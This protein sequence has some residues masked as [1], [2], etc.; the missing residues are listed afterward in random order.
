MKITLFLLF[1]FTVVFAANS[2]FSRIRVAAYDSDGVP[3]E[4]VH[5]ISICLERN[6][7]MDEKR[8][9]EEVLGYYADGIYEATN[10]ANFLGN[11]IIYSGA[12]NCSEAD[13]VWMK[14]G[15]WPG[16]GA[17][18]GVSDVWV[19]GSDVYPKMDDAKERFDFGITLAHETIHL[20]Y[21]LDDDYAKTTSTNY[22]VTLLADSHND[23]IVVMLDDINNEELL[24]RYK[25]WLQTTFS[26]GSP[27]R[28]FGIGEGRV[29]DG[30]DMGPVPYGRDHDFGHFVTDYPIIDQVDA[31][32]LELGYY[33]FNLKD[34]S[35]RRIDIK[36][37]G[38]EEWG[39]DRPDDVSVA[40]SIMHYQYDVATSS[41]CDSDNIQW[42]WANL[43]TSFNINPSSPLGICC[44]DADGNLLSAWDILTRNPKTNLI[45]GKYPGDDFRY[46]Y[47][48]LLKKKPKESDVF[49]AKS[50]LMNYDENTGKTL[51]GYA[52]WVRNEECGHEK[53]YNLPYMKVEL[54]GRNPSEYRTETHKHLNIQWVD[55]SEMEVIILV[56]RS[57]S[58]NKVYKDQYGNVVEKND[59]NPLLKID[60]A[61]MAAKFVS[62]GVG[63]LS[64]TSSGADQTESEVTVGVYVFDD[65]ISSVYPFVKRT[66]DLDEIDASVDV[67]R[68]Q[69]ATALFDALYSVLG[70]FSFNSA[71]KKM[72]YVISDGLDVSS[73]H[74]KD[75]VIRKSKNRDI[76]IHTFAYGEHADVDLLSSMATETNGT[77]YEDDAKF[78]K[79]ITDVVSTALAS[80]P[81]NEQIQAALIAANQTS[82][83]IYVP[84]R[85]KYAKIYGSYNGSVASS[86]IEIVSKSGSVLPF[87]I[88]NNAALNENYF[89]AEI[90]SL[91]LANL[92]EPFIKVKNKL[93]DRN[94]DF[95]IIATNE[96]HDYSLNVK[97]NPSGAFEWPSQ[98]N[99]KAS[100]RSKDGF[101]ADVV[102][103]GKLTDPDGNVQTF[104]LHDD[105]VNGDFRAGD[106]VFFA[107]LPSINKNGS[108]QWEIS[109]SNKNGLAH[110]TRIGTSLPDTFPFVVKTDNT[111][112]ELFHNGQFVVRGCCNDEPSDNLIQLPP[113][114][115]VNAFLQ[116][117]TDVDRFE[118]VGTQAGKS[119]SLRLSSLDL[120]SFDKI[121]IYSASD[122]EVPVYTVDVE[123]DNTKGFVTVPLA[124]EYALPGYIVS[125]VGSNSNGANYDL[126]LLEKSYAEFAIGRFEID[127]DW[128]SL[129]TT[130]SLDSK[131]KSEGM[132]SLVTPAGW[133][134]IESRNVS[135]ADFELVGEKMSL[136]VYVPL[137]TQNVYWIGNV[138]L[139]MSVP[140]SNKRVQIGQQQ[141]IQPYFGNWMSYEFDM[142]AQ[143]LELLSEPHSDIRFQIILNSADS[144]WIDN[145]RFAGT[146]SANPVNKWTPQCPEDNGCDSTRPLQLRVNESIRVVAEGDLWIEIVGFPND[147]TPAKVNVGVS[148]EDGASLTGHMSFENET[149]PL[150]G[151]YSEPS[152][153]FVS[154]KRYL[155]KLYNLGGR[156]YRLNAWTMGGTSG[157]SVVRSFESSVYEVDFL[158][159][160]VDSQTL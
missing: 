19:Y 141:N 126:L 59:G 82:S 108:Y 10:G 72:L 105:G 57:L 78:P 32:S 128:H 131:K 95:R 60:M 27:I 137:Q 127:G 142:P 28:F 124:A 101:L 44:R 121:V 79:K 158:P 5:D 20:R 67:I 122:K 103:M 58:M 80:F 120:Q 7:T 77:F 9:Y 117:G 129:E 25:T 86:P 110:T 66:P 38:Y 98:K 147:W 146:M 139:W 102:F 31:S 125:V 159:N 152:F 89:V 155:L 39:F 114:T 22:G 61:R 36:D 113:E 55:N 150:I 6:P 118:I 62:Q 149:I 92:S 26:S 48:S 35:G 69:G 21:A 99:F 96:Y 41:N 111:P 112:F 46:W 144:L 63:S 1:A 123:H 29:P 130:V 91:T 65:V 17:N 94:V 52:V 151:W 15:L 34:G 42:Q 12:K 75:D 18:I 143:A 109:A 100:V 24:Y 84:R 157:M 13:I 47:K 156:P 140:S 74:T 116:S 53:T 16:A 136:D 30:L 8:K 37:A 54:A 70:Y 51:P 14:Y 3:S 73:T 107:N 56:D 23:A 85:T 43:S 50:F 145:L 71:S 2:P 93:N 134:T 83:E 154:G 115:R 135:S 119:Y 81:D 160:I 11:V 90:D 64:W 153:D 138:E 88:K 4:E 87:L 33:S 40:H 148:A 97:L 133:K 68:P 45:N 132:K 49:R 104:T 76:A 106:G